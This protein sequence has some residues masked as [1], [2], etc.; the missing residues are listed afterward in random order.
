MHARI[1]FRRI[2]VCLVSY[3]IFRYISVLRT[4]YHS[5]KTNIRIVLPRLQIPQHLKRRGARAVCSP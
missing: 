1:F 4:H 2:Y 5:D 3:F